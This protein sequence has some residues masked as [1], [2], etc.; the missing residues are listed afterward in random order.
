MDKSKRQD[1]K[2]KGRKHHFLPYIL[3][4]ALFGLGAGITGEILIQTYFLQDIT[5]P[6]LSSEYN[7]SDLNYNRSGLI[8]R[9]A[10]KVVVSQDVKI[11]ET[12]SAVEPSM[13][14]VFKKINPTAS[15]SATSSNALSEAGSLDEVTYY[16]LDNPDFVA[17][18][19]SSD[20][21]ATVSM[22]ANL[23]ST[24]VAE[25]YVAI[26]NSRQIYS[27]D[28]IVQFAN[29]PGNLLFFHLKDANNM[30]VR[31]MLMRPDISLGQSVLVVSDYDSINPVN[32]S[33][34][35][36][37][38]GV[39]SSDEV[40]ISLELSQNLGSEFS[41]SFVFD[42]AG[43]LV[44]IIDSDLEAIPAFFYSHH[45]QSFFQDKEYSSPSLGINYLD[46]S[47]NKV[48]GL[49]M[50]KGAL[51]QASTSSPAVLSGSAA[52][53]A[54][55]QAGDIILWVN[56]QE[57]NSENSLSEIIAS[58]NSLDELSLIYLRDGDEYST[59]VRL[60]MKI[61]K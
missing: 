15:Q 57:L 59:K 41:N 42:L 2:G 53:I 55:L 5:S 30:P 36:Q 19:I 40:N 27:L 37:R 26:D 22:P 14:R 48:L 9:D 18:S 1:K 25:D 39:L 52:D 10:K 33:G 7:L 35:K 24:F 60:Q 34:L 8:I 17:L 56:N 12:I 58:Y 32:V 45:W 4:A 20:G 54:G 28:E 38:S 50:S 47:Y 16:S 44:A 29:L 13:L 49:D 23:A 11:E 6:Y 21:W 3:L 61:E 51:L 46:L 43:N 31:S